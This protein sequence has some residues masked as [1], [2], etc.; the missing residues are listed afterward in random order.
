MCIIPL[1]LE[2]RFEQR[3]AARFSRP[4]EAAT[5]QKHRLKGQ[6]EPFA[7]LL[8]EKRKTRRVEP[9]GLRPLPTV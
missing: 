4:K 6:S 1:D 8:K 2:R 5:F 3:W 7:A 9:A